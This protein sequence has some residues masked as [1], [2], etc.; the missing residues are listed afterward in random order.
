MEVRMKKREERR[1]RTWR[2]ARRAQLEH[3]W[4]AHRNRE[5]D[6]PCETSVWYFAKRKVLGCNCRGRTHGNPK[7]GAGLCHLGMRPAVEE[8]IAGR[9][10]CRHWFDAE[11]E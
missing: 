5:A 6:C 2:A 4:A 1:D 10:L 8:R 7:Y 11:V 9:R 3:L